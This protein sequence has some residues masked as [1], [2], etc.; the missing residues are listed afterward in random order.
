MPDQIRDQNA[1]RG[2][3]DPDRR[4]QGGHDSRRDP[5]NDQDGRFAQRSRH[6]QYSEW[7]WD[8]TRRQ[9]FYVDL[10]SG[11]SIYED[12]SRVTRRPDTAGPGRQ[13]VP[14]TTNVAPTQIA[15][16]G[17]Q[18]GPRQ[19]EYITAPASTSVGPSHAGDRTERAR[20]ADRAGSGPSA[21]EFPMPTATTRED[22][23]VTAFRVSARNFGASLTQLSS[24]EIN[25]IAHQPRNDQT[26]Y[27]LRLLHAQDLNAYDRAVKALQARKAAEEDANSGSDSEEDDSHERSHVDPPVR[28]AQ[29]GR[30][31]GERGPNGSRPSASSATRQNPEAAKP[32]GKGKSTAS[33]R[34]NRSTEGTTRS[35]NA[36]HPQDSGPR[37]RVD[38]HSE[39]WGQ[40]VPRRQDAA[41]GRP[42]VASRDRTNLSS[43]KAIKNQDSES[44]SGT[45]SQST[46]EA[47]SEA[48]GPS[49]SLPVR[50]RPAVPT[51]NA[52]SRSGHRRQ[53][54]EQAGTASGRRGDKARRYAG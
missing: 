33:G 1:V 50:S 21:R 41:S 3:E 5:D 32:E 34:Q 38:S 45:E 14:R 40:S 44:D 15:P 6:P 7:T 23:A 17:R 2:E 27:L 11:D 28:P 13:T 39:P 46:S 25:T 37:K 51:A 20:H 12:G 48:K 30:Q 16:P 47:E 9:Y 26:Q 19:P 4:H 18:A 35:A 29:N 8:A 43:Q 54:A 31:V 42:D 52:G 22:Q 36:S 24:A 49:R 53:H 10:A